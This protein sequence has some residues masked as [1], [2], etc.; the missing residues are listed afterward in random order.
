LADGA[1]GLWKALPQVFGTTRA[2]RCWLHKT[3]NVLN[4][5]PKNLQANANPTCTRSGR[6]AG[7]G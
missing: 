2:Q 5:L 7:T 4:K 3:A 1:L 6:D